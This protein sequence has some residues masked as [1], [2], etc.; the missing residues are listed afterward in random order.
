MFDVSYVCGAYVDVIFRM[1]AHN[2]E[3]N[4]VDQ[5][6]IHQN[7]NQSYKPFKIKQKT[8]I[9]YIVLLQPRSAHT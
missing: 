1:L 2:H 9:L 5:H 3:Q 7:Q 8:I 6:N 4:L